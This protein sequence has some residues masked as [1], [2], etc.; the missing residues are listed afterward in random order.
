MLLKDKV[1]LVTGGSRG[2]GKQIAL[3]LAQEGADIVLGA[4][5][6]E[7]AESPFPG[8]IHETAAEIRALGAKVLA[9]RCDLAIRADMER[10]CR[11]AIDEFGRVD[12]LINNAAYFGPGHYDPFLSLTLDQWDTMIAVD[13]NAP[14]QACR[15]LLPGMIERGSGLILC[16]TSVA[17]THDV[18][19]GGRGGISPG[20]PSAKAGL[21]RFVRALAVEI[22]EHRIP[23]IAVEPGFTMTERTSI[24]L[25]QNNVDIS[26]AHPMEVPVRTMHYLCTCDDPMAYS[27][28]V[29]IA[30]DFVR[31]HHLL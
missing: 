14:A 16:M 1:V 20:Y 3:R 4:R 26:K 22:K 28:Q 29:V 10:L 31:K 24:I 12:I 13:L 19:P 18:A 25:P 27:G 5:T 6:V 11:S 23:V 9:V 8:T 7:A 2:I 15:L 17:A 30:A 21:N